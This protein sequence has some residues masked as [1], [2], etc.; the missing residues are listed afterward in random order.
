MATDSTILHPITF[1]SKSLTDAECRYSNIKCE[2]LGIL[3]DLEKFHHYCSG[4]E[5]LF[6]TDHKPLVSM[7]KIDI[8]TLSQFIQGILLKFTNIWSRLYTK[9]VPRSL[10]WTGYQETTI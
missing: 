4:R 3:H 1:A 9:V 5:V 6:I 8:A 10:L 7:F 2:V